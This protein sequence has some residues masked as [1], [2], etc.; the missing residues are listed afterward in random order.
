MFSIVVLAFLTA[1]G[2]L[3][4]PFLS[5]RQSSNCSGGLQMFIARGSL[6]P[7]GE[8]VE[9][10][11]PALVQQSI[12]GSKAEGIVYPADPNNYFT[13]EPEGVSAMTQAIKNYT[14]ACPT[15]KFALLG[16]SQGANVVSDVIGGS[17]L[18]AAGPGPIDK[19]YTKNRKQ[20]SCL[21]IRLVDL[22]KVVPA[23]RATVAAIILFADPTHVA[24]KSYNVGTSTK[25]GVSDDQ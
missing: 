5:T 24:G 14:Q 21:P 7:Q 17:F 23:K 15:G 20:K 8:G 6:E 16:Y 22:D 3:A 13:S 4:S 9:S 1:T 11:V 19:S 10:C 25:N 12:P 18:G 2:S